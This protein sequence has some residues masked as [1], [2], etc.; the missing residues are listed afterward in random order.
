MARKTQSGRERSF[1]ANRNIVQ[2][3]KH[4]HLLTGDVLR[5]PRL[6]HVPD[7]VVRAE[8]E[9]GRPIYNQF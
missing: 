7:D 2:G 6:A 4:R 3:T 9:M 5:A 8:W 1:P